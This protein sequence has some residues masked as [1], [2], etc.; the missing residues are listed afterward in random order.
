MSSWLRR[1]LAHHQ[2]FFVFALLSACSKEDPRER[3]LEVLVSA[4]AETLDPRLSTDTTSVRTTRLL[5]AGLFRLDPDTLLPI[6]Y[7]AASYTWQDALTLEITLRENVK[8][9]S[10]AA[11]ESEDVKASL[12]AYQGPL[13]RHRRVVDQIARI[14][15]IDSKHV[16]IVLKGPHATLLSDLEVPILR[17]DQAAHAPVSGLDTL[18]GL[19]PYALSASET[20][21]GQLTLRPR[22][23]GAFPKPAHAI[24]IRTVRDE[25]ARALRIRA[26]VADVAVNAVS[27][28]LLP[29]LSGTAARPAANLTY[30]LVRDSERLPYAIRHALSLAIDRARITR[31]YF[32]G[33]AEPAQSLIPSVHWAHVDSSAF[34]TYNQ[35]AA[36]SVLAGA[37]YRTDLTDP[38]LHLSLHTST[39]RLRMSIAR[40]LKQELHHVGIELELVPLEL[41]SMIARLTEGAFE[42]A[43]L[44]IPELTEPNAFRTFLHSSSMPPLGSNRGRANNPALDKLLDEGSQT[45]D[46]QARKR[47]YGAL[48]AEIERT[49]PMIPLW[50]EQ[51]VT[52]TSERA[53]AFS[54]SAEGRW[55]SLAAVP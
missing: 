14:D 21:R 32:A 17:R 30:M 27:P 46:S 35:E 43:I 51:W 26:G 16:A 36:R 31:T 53:R 48:E 2:A 39:D 13:S 54:P 6:P 42:L 28:T 4:E 45:K 47:I 15:I 11:F 44:Q 9:A 20:S 18:D 5:H 19:G 24:V 49:L 3:P 50:H 55:L 23:F 40:F 41:G 34:Y 12:L 37:G 22:D 29:S 33:Y 25:N 52:V 38:R 1:I 8:F 7:A 10:G